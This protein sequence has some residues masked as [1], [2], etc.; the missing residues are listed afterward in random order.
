MVT[1]ANISWFCFN[2]LAQTLLESPMWIFSPKIND[3][4]PELFEIFEHVNVV[5]CIKTWCLSWCTD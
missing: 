4:G 2:D 1:A 5:H 3:I